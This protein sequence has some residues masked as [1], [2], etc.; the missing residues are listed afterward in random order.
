MRK[1]WTKV[2]MNVSAEDSGETVIRIT[3]GAK[4]DAMASV[5]R[6]EWFEPDG[7]EH[8]GYAAATEGGR[9]LAADVIAELKKSR[10]VVALESEDLWNPVWGELV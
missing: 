2:P 5:E 9:R 4:G 8:T 3:R 10:A 7:H 1:K 6:L